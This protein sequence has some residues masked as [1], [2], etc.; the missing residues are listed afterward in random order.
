[1]SPP[2]RFV[3][4]TRASRATPSTSMN[5][6]TPSHFISYAHASPGGTSCT[7]VASIGRKSDGGGTRSRGRRRLIRRE[8]Y[9]FLAVARPPLRPAALCCAVVPPCRLSPPEPDFLPPWLDAFGE[10]A[11]FAARSFD[12]PFS[13]KASYCFLFFTCAVFVGIVTPFAWNPSGPDPSGAGYPARRLGI[14][15]R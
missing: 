2:L 15:R 10:L 5:A 13:F 12:M 4:R 9:L 11:I 14:R 7:S 3:T 6:R 8:F 1:M